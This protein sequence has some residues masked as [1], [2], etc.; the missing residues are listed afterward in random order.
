M[1]GQ[2]GKKH[3]TKCDVRQRKKPALLTPT[4]P[5]TIY[6]SRGRTGSLSQNGVKSHS[7]KPIIRPARPRNSL[8]LVVDAL[9]TNKPAPQ[10]QTKVPVADMAPPG[11]SPI[12]ALA[13]QAMTLLPTAASTQPHSPATDNDT[14]QDAKV[15]KSTSEAAPADE[16]TAS[17]WVDSINEG[18]KQLKMLY[19]LTRADRPPD[20]KSSTTVVQSYIRNMHAFLLH[21][22]HEVEPKPQFKPK[23]E[24][25]LRLFLDPVLAGKLSE[26]AP[27]IP[28]LAQQVLDKYESENWGQDLTDNEEDGLDAD[29]IGPAVVPLGNNNDTPS[30]GSPSSANTEVIK[31]PPVSHPI[32][33]RQGIMHGLARRTSAQGRV[34]VILNPSYQQEKRNARVFGHNGHKPGTWWPYQKAAL[35][36]GA[37]GSPQAGITGDPERGT[38]SIVV[39][40]TSAYR[41]LNQDQGTVL[42]Y[43]ADKSTENA[44]PVSTGETSNATASLLQARKKG[45]PV[46]VLRHSGKSTTA[47][48]RRSFIY[49][50]VGIRYDG[51]YKIVD[52]D[53]GTNKH[54][55]AIKLFK[56]VRL[57][58]SDNEGVSWEDIQKNP[59]KEQLRQFDKIKDAY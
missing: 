55:G 54:G 56:L 22:E 12:Q 58:D 23:L 52:Q 36:H 25:L 39:S 16:N 53:I 35:F 27:D 14:N 15:A 1:K 57:P 31:L 11:E 50:T 28:R 10:V 37:H 29:N 59:T 7:H 30:S 5:T 33:G 3:T 48:S 6:K 24:S 44:S 4:S 43:S 42:W 34:V 9:Q 17:V 47:D 21:L 19:S 8:S 13:A 2:L 38:F 26:M 45:T 32:W 51:L 49:P 41:D 18:I 46:R 40:A 20:R